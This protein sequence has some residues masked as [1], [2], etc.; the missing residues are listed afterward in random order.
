MDF[1]E[2]SRH[3]S[4][5][6]PILE[7]SLGLDL[8]ALHRAK[9]EGWLKVE[10]CGLLAPHCESV[11]P[12]KQRIDIC[13]DE[14]AIELKTVNTNIRYV[15]IQNKSRPITKNTES[16][17]KDIEGLKKLDFPMKAVLFIVFPIEHEN[18]HWQV[19]IQRI[20]KELTS[21]RMFP[22]VFKGGVAKGVVYFGLV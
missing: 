8:F 12:E 19:Q 5:I 17:I 22:F 7:N 1:N 13:A 10:V 4:Q 11:I 16:I 2:L 21:L 20:K 14:W 9:F 6:K 3:V 15:G 18:K